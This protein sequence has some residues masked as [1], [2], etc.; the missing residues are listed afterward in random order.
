MR[1]APALADGTIDALVSDHTPVDED[2][3][4]LPFA[5]AEPGATGL[6]LLLGLALKW[7]AER[8]G[9][10]LAQH[11]RRRVTSRPAPCSATR[12]ARSAASAARPGT[13]ARVGR[14][15]HLR[16]DRP[17]R[18]TADAR[19]PAAK[20]TPFAGYELPGRGALHARRRPR[21]L[22]GAAD[23]DAR[24]AA[25]A[26]RRRV[27]ALRAVVRLLRASATACTALAIVLFAFPALDAAARHERIRWW[28]TKMLRV[29]GI[30]CESKARREPARSLLAVNH[31]SWLDIMAIHAVAPDARFVSK[32][33]V[34][35]W[36]L[37]GAPGRLRPARS[38]SSASASAMRC[39]SST[40]SPRRCTPARRSRCFPRARR[41]P[42]TACCRSTPTCCRRR[43]PPRRRCSRSRCASRMP[44]HAGQRGGRVRRRDQPAAQ[45]VAASACGD[46]VGRPAGVPAAA[47]VGQAS[48][49]A[50]SPGGCAPTSP[51]ALGIAALAAAA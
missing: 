7:G 17:G 14:P 51:R 20:H 28:S 24:A 42:A 35:A 43:S 47:P 13:K 9:S 37:L 22:R 21:R 5:E 31:I 2:A 18:S 25:R 27:R 12:S 11:A 48:S 23:R 32:A 10:P 41:R 45:P 8:P 29:L 49:G 30:A 46:G 33:D 38:T 36:P 15:L 6:E 4:H 19:E 40:R 50:S 34:K 39:A 26:R 44:S 3:K 1:S 16:P